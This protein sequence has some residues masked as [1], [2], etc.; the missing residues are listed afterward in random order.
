MKYGSI[1]ISPQV[2]VQVRVFYS[3]RIKVLINVFM[4]VFGYTKHGHCPHLLFG[5][6]DDSVEGR[7]YRVTPVNEDI[8]LGFCA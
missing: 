5:V 3:G 7:N 1:I 4:C 2:T 6:G 8:S